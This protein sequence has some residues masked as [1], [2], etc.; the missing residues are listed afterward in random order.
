MTGLCYKIVFPIK[1]YVLFV[2]VVVNVCELSQKAQFAIQS[3][4]TIRRLDKLEIMFIINKY[5]EGAGV[6]SSRQL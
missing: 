3:V 6:K 4:V 1:K 2:V 5:K